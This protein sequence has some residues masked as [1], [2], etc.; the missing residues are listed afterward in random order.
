MIIYYKDILYMFLFTLIAGIFCTRYI[1]TSENSVI[2]TGDIPRYEQ[3][4]ERVAI[5]N[6]FFD[7]IESEDL[8]SYILSDTNVLSIE[9]DIEISLNLFDLQRDPVWNLDRIDQRSG[10]LDKKYFYNSK[11]GESVNVFVLDTGIDT[12]HQEF[13]GRASWG[14][15]TVD[16]DNIN[17]HPH[18]THVAGTIGS[19]TYGVAK[20]TN[21][22]AV[23]VLNKDG[24][25]TSSSVLKGI[26]YVIN[27]DRR[28]KIIN[29]S[30]GGGYSQALNRAVEIAV[31]KG[32]IVVSA[33][34]NENQDACNTSPG[35]SPETIT[36][37]AFGQVDNIAYFSNW[38]SC[39]D[40]F[41]P[42]VDIWSTMPGGGVGKM[43]GT[44][45]ATPMTA[46]V[47][48]LL[49]DG[50]AEYTPEKVKQFL[51]KTATKNMLK[52]DLR[53]SPNDMIFSI[54]AFFF[55]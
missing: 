53:G 50:D 41:A 27:D 11:A 4:I 18:G 14:T 45:M 19:E 12:S 31:Q 40:I 1:V 25:G 26:E 20:K 16:N 10:K 15:N 33:A 17:L 34:G 22:I 49:I 23:K 32:V 29:M 39:V 44:S 43:S 24:G 42:G 47:V 21:L 35:S 7:I 51:K 30:L 5:G 54:P 52:G 48:A 28:K 55:Q 9:E 38:G 3:F 8:P 6:M 36:V 13:K 2:N 37:G 46:G